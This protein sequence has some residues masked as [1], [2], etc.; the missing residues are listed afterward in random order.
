MLRF[1]P[2]ELYT[3]LRG[4]TLWLIGDSHT[5]NF[6]PAMRCFML[7]FFQHSVGECAA[8]TD[9]AL[10]EQLQRVA[11][12]PPKQKSLK[13]TSPPRC[14]ALVGGGRICMVQAVRGE[15][16]V[17]DNPQAAPGVLQLLHQRLASPE[18]IFLVGFGRWYTPSCSYDAAAYAASLEKLGR[19]YEVTLTRRRDGCCLAACDAPLRPALTFHMHSC[20]ALHVSCRRHACSG[21]TSS[22]RWRHTITVAPPARTGR[23]LPHATA[24][25]RTQVRAPHASPTAAA[26]AGSRVRRHA[27]THASLT[28]AAAWH[29]RGAAG[30]AHRQHGTQH[31]GQVSGC[32]LG[33]RSTAH[34]CSCAGSTTLPC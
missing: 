15:Q 16:L 21:Q 18:D 6:Y 24:R 28:L 29:R 10:Q 27:D 9:A 11:L 25:R 14:V 13:A 4:R 20:A 32:T 22:F 26:A 12:Y 17:S 30:P 3:Y 7:D 31:S 2:C 8:T 23:A 34:A 19:F 1:S 33:P 5:K